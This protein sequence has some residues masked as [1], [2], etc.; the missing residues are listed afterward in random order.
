MI[1]SFVRALVS[2]FK[3]RCELALEWVHWYNTQRL[4]EPIGNV[5]AIAIFQ[6]KLDIIAG[7]DDPDP[8]EESRHDEKRWE[9]RAHCHSVVSRYQRV[10][11]LG[12]LVGSPPSDP[13]DTRADQMSIVGGGLDDEE[14]IAEDVEL[15][16]KEG[17]ESGAERHH[18]AVTIPAATARKSTRCGI[19]P[20]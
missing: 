2:A 19:A 18:P 8:L 12:G 10:E 20:R 7:A 1:S 5:E 6:Q 4:L 17:F 14:A 13:D 15:D 11:D 3:A 9:F 16:R